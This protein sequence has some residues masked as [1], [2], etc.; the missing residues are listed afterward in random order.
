MCTRTTHA[1]IWFWHRRSC[2]LA[3]WA[4]S[5]MCSPFSVLL[6]IVT[7]W[8]TLLTPQPLMLPNFR[9]ICEC[10][11]Q[12]KLLNGVDTQ[13]AGAEAHRQRQ[14]RSAV[15][16]SIR[17]SEAVCAKCWTSE[18]PL[19]HAVMPSTCAQASWACGRCAPIQHQSL[20]PASPCR[21]LSL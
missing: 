15:K 19:V 1:H 8:T 9:I 12:M 4:T 5:P 6:E 18:T 20:P 3:C 10:S 14:P 13:Q 7:V 11:H 21:P 2:R 16:T 17:R